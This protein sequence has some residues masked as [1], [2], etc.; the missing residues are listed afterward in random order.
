MSEIK[1]IG[2]DTTTGKRK[3]YISGDT[4]QG[5]E[6]GAGQ[7]GPPGIDGED[8]YD[9]PIIPG[10]DGVSVVGPR[11]I[12]GQDG[13]DGR[14]AWVIPGPRGADGVGT[15]G[16]QGPPGMGIPGVDGEDE[17]SNWPSLA[18]HRHVAAD[19]SDR[20]PSNKY[21]RDDGT[22]QPVTASLP[23]VVIMKMTPTASK[24]IPTDYSVIIARRYV[25]S[26]VFNL[27]IEGTGA[28]RIE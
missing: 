21:L 7:Q 11:G 16:S 26:G 5:V 18:T 27:T 17:N 22:W 1:I 14:D 9:T 28:L 24:T 4:I 6:G 8:G 12:P 10:R 23:E 13:E 19:I 3:V 20:T 25:I 2:I 15:P